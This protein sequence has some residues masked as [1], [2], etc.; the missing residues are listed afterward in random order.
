M[1][2]D[3]LNRRCVELFHHPDVRLRCWHPRMFWE[4]G[5]KDN[6]TPDELICPKVDLRELEVLLAESAHVPSECADE[7]EHEVPGRADRIRHMV[8]R[9]EMPFLHR[10]G[11]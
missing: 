10:P 9:G 2:E 4:T 5:M 7:L 6:P 1:T 3:E 11:P 8:R